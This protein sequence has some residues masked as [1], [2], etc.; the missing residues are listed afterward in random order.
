MP[1][2]VYKAIH[3]V[4]IFVLVATLAAALSRPAPSPVASER[5]WGWGM[6]GALFLVLLG[7]FGLMARIGIGHGDGLP[8]WIWI[9]LGIWGV[10]VSLAWWARSGRSASL[11][12]F[13]V[14]PAL[15]ALAGLVAWTKPF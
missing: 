12:L 4:G 11:L 8:M 7:G 13:G 5:R 10:M 6:A 2:V 3:Y 1:Y 14:V 15:A 9:K